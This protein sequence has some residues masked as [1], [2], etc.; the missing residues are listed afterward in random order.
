LVVG[1]AWTAVQDVAG[2][3]LLTM[4]IVVRDL[5]L[6]DRLVSLLRQGR[7]RHPGDTVMAEVVPWFESPV[8]F[9]TSTEAMEAESRSMDLFA[10]DPQYSQFFREVRGSSQQSPVELP[11]LDVE[12]GVLIAV[13]RVLGD[14]VALALDYRGSSS[15][16]RVVASDWWTDPKTCA[17][18]LVAPSFSSFAGAIGL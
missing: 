8:D 9:L 13:N 12:Q 15:E 17:W 7:W 14:D 11:W 18:R 1:H 5:E 6:P 2:E 3:R 10:D 16:P 4:K